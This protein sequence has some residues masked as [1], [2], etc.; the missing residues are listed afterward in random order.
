MTDKV[1]TEREENIKK[2]I[3]SML[4]PSD[5]VVVVGDSLEDSGLPEGSE[6]LIAATQAI[7]HDEEDIYNL[8]MHVIIHNVVDGHVDSSRLLMVDPKN[9][10]LVSEERNLE[11]GHIFTLDFAVDEENDVEN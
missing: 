3:D 1:L 6:A 11:L 5:F 7:P 4:K 9:V 8:R 2:K 10:K